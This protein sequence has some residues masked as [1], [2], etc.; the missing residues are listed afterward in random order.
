M[1]SG[2]ILEKTCGFQCTVTRRKK[3]LLYLQFFKC[4]GFLSDCICGTVSS[5]LLFF[6]NKLNYVPELGDFLVATTEMT[7][8]KWQD[9]VNKL[10]RS[11][12]GSVWEVCRASE[13]VILFFLA[14]FHP[15]PRS[16][17]WCA[18]WRHLISLFISE[19]CSLESGKGTDTCLQHH[20]TL[21]SSC[22][23][24]HR[25]DKTVYHGH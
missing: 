10:P 11:R 23:P 14:T 21:P 1:W 12:T 8:D 16:Y 24:H 6:N 25:E 15:P 18:F 3:Q 5:L 4:F 9:A 7:N 22:L 20:R 19:A 13:Q 17:L 2:F